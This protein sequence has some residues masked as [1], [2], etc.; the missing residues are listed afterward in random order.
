MNQRKRGFVLASLSLLLLSS[1]GNK[2]ITYTPYSYTK[3]SEKMLSFSSSDE[4]LD[5]FLNDY[6]KRHVGYVDPEGNDWK[7]TSVKAGVNAKEFFWQE[8][9]TLMYDYFDSANGLESNRLEGIRNRQRTIPVDRY[10]FVWGSDDETKPLTQD[11]AQNNRHSMGWPFPTSAESEGFAQSW[12]FNSVDEKWTSNIEAAQNQ[13]LLM[14]QTDEAGLNRIDFISPLLDKDHTIFTWHAPFLELDL[15]MYTVDASSIDDVYVYYK[16]SASEDWSEEKRVSFHDIAAIDYDFTPYYEH[17]IY[18]PMFA[19]PE[20]N[21]LKNKEIYQLKIEI[22]AKGERK[23]TGRF[24]LNY[25]RSAYDTRHT[26]NI[27]KFI[28]ALQNDYRLT[29]DLSYLQEE[30][31]RARKG[32]NFLLSMYDEGRHLND[33]SRLIGHDGDKNFVN[34]SDRLS[35][36]L[37]NGYWDVLF[38]SRYDFQT[39][40]F[41]YKALKSLSY[42]EAVAEQYQLPVSKKEATTLTASTDVKESYGTKE[43]QETSASLAQKAQ[44]VLA[45]LRE[46][47][48][49]EAKTG[50]YDPS[51]GR[52]IEGYN[53]QGE[54]MDWGYTMWNLEAI[55][56]GVAT[57]EQAKSIMSWINGDRVIALDESGSQG[58]DIY[59][60]EFAP[61][62]TT[63]N[64]KG[65]F[66]GSYRVDPDYGKKQVQYGGAI[67]Y[68]S[69]YDLLARIQVLGA[70]NAFS[71]LQSIENW[72]QKIYD[73]FTQ[74]RDIV[75]PQNFY[76]DYY[77][78][79]ENITIQSGIHSA[80]GGG[81]GLLG[82][83]GEFLESLLLVSAIPFG[84][85]GLKSQ[86]NILS[87]APKLPSSL[88]YWKMENLLF[89]QVRYDCTILPH[90]LQIDSVRGNTSGL[91][92]EARLA[93]PEGNFTV[94]VNGKATNDY[95]VVDQEIVLSVP[96]HSATIL[97]I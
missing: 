1:C 81:S 38:M 43:Y 37:T 5:F 27:C 52:F 51:V 14:G 71:R 68:T 87:F 96:F 73:Y 57:E 79:V 20:W 89:H 63:V 78:N 8:W 94:Y 12:D 67:M 66:N 53:A 26:N 46:E 86:D 6:F 33:Q 92:L 25:V 60:F 47:T 19:A 59:R 42:L 56:E 9:S 93:K 10:G 36:S 18:L 82:L 90:G 4:G 72:Y 61:R 83:D 16:T 77:R 75:T 58:K 24:G 23:L 31:T 21:S 64:K 29:G 41:F 15:R 54:K 97:A 22:Q 35:H 88:T 49:D 40:V 62:A 48:N 17:I 39:N 13:G 7:V 11:V 34:D 95:Q 30:L 80:E 70:D 28:D 44:D 85:F 91:T 3:E 45:A 55:V 32:M 65:T 50:F 2:E 69:F 76:W 84:F 74:N